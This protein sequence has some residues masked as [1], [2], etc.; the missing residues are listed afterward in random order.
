MN[1]SYKSNNQNAEVSKINILLHINPNPIGTI[2]TISILADTPY[3]SL[4][5]KNA[6]SKIWFKLCL[7]CYLISV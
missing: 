6:N 3:T 7:I 1:I 5:V 4:P 2:L